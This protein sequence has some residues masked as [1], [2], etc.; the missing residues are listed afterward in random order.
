MHRIR[1]NLLS[2]LT[3]ELWKKYMYFRVQVVCIQNRILLSQKKGNLASGNNMDGPR[4]V[5]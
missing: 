1:E 3:K 5:F 2:Y 4:A